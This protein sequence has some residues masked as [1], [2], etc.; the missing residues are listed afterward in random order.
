[1]G[2]AAS[3]S[4]KETAAIPSRIA[5]RTTMTWKMGSSTTIPT[6]LPGGELKAANLRD[7]LW[8]A[9]SSRRYEMRPI[10]VP[11]AHIAAAGG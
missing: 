9:F 2:G 7:T 8:I 4:R 1:M 10:A 11:G 5:A 3:F 6:T